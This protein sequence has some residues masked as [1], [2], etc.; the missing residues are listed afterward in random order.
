MP[1]DQEVC[2]FELKLKM[3]RV[4]LTQTAQV[5]AEHQGCAACKANGWIAMGKMGDTIVQCDVCN[6]KKLLPHQL[7]AETEFGREVIRLAKKYGRALGLQKM[8]LPSDVKW[9]VLRLE[10][11]KKER[12]VESSCSRKLTNFFENT[13]EMI[14]EGQE[15]W[16]K[17]SDRSYLSRRLPVCRAHEIVDHVLGFDAHQNTVKIKVAEAHTEATDQKLKRNKND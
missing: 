8:N 16:K 10:P 17:Q 5:V 11:A 3:H 1:D 4:H 6:G 13:M 15:V 14:G 7:D 9:V 2:E 12:D